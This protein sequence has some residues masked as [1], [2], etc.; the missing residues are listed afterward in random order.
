MNWNTPVKFKIGDVDWEM[1]LS[2]LLLVV[3]LTVIL[4]AAGGG[5]GYQFGSG[6]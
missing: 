4:M 3:A 6:K 2:T 5:L 1:P